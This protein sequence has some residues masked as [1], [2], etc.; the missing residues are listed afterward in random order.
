MDELAALIEK[1]GVILVPFN[2]KGCPFSQLRAA[3]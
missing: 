3:G 1:G 2:D